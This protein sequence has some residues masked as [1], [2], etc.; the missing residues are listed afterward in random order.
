MKRIFVN[1]TF[2][3]IHRGHI[4]LLYY[5]KSLGDYLTVAID[6]DERVRQLK[7]N[8]RPINCLQD[9]MF[10]LQSLKP[11][12]RVRSFG[13]DSGLEFWIR[14]SCSNIMV[15]GSDYKDKH[16]VGSD[17]VDEIIF[18]DIVDGYSTTKTIQDIITR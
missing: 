8:S 1:G 10:L 6:S 18:Y 12:D 15:K 7:G 5:A 4:E 3:I 11:V 17:L 16:I 14:Q 13:S 9:R 2:D